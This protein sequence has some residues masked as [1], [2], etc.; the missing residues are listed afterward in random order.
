MLALHQARWVQSNLQRL[1]GDQFQIVEIET[2][3]DQKLDQALWQIDGKDFFSKELDRALLAGKVDLVVHSYKDL[4]TQRPPGLHLAA[5]TQRAHA[6]DILLMPFHVQKQLADLQTLVVGTS[7]PRRMANLRTDLASFLPHGKQLTIAPQILR[8]NVFTRI[9][10][11]LEGKYQA[12]ILALAGLERLSGDP[13]TQPLLL[14]LLKELNF[15]ILPQSLFPSAAAQGAL[16]IECLEKR[17][18]GDELLKKIRHLHHPETWEAVERERVAFRAYGGG[19]HLG[20]GIHVDRQGPFYLHTHRGE[21]E[22]EKVDKQFLEP[23]ILPKISTPIKKENIFIGLPKNKAPEHFVCDE[24]INKMPVPLTAKPLQGFHYFTSDYT[25]DA[26]NEYPGFIFSAGTKTWKT[27][28]NAGRWVHATSDGLGDD[29]VL[30]LAKNNFFQ[31][32]RQLHHI[33]D[34]KFH[35]TH[36]QVRGER[37]GQPMATYRHE[38]KTP[39]A[40]FAQSMANVKICFW[41]SWTQYQTYLKIFPQLLA[42]SNVTHCCGLGMSY[43][44]FQANKI[45]VTPFASTKHFFA[46][47]EEIAKT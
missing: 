15:M 31:E 6:A 1:T 44:Q 43:T 37:F 32:Y 35:Y 27:I 18:D 2:E 41:T 9:N 25:F 19:C 4:G 36:D 40:S 24:I 21:H 23:Q 45:S 10:R 26:K 28:T 13:V 7:S 20:V 42:Q 34:H 47:T 8:G 11:L 17:A 29:Q 5:V 39:E 14:P 33:P 30:A 46:W 22:G 38:I 12:I 16:A 3:G